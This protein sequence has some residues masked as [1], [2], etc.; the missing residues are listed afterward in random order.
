[1]G[2]LLGDEVLWLRASVGGS[3]V[4]GGG[5]AL[6]GDG[7]CG[8]GV[9][10]GAYG[11]SVYGFLG[12]WVTVPCVSDPGGMGGDW[13]GLMVGEVGG[14]A[15]VGVCWETPSPLSEYWCGTSSDLLRRSRSEV[16]ILLDGRE[17]FGE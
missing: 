13:G 12:D 5:G 16:K 11:D 9:V 17:F 10:G 14:L 2:F 15:I 6:V 4:V 8:R 3:G 7:D 1:M